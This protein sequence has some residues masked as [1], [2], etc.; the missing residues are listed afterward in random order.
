MWFGLYLKYVCLCDSEPC[1]GRQ[2]MCGQLSSWYNGGGEKRSEKMP[3]V[4]RPVS[5]K[6]AGS[7]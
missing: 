6:Y 7:H 2:L 1:G 4:C 5:K 3:A